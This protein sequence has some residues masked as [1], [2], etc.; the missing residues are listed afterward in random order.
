MIE[1]TTAAQS[2]RI[3]TIEKGDGGYPASHKEEERDGCRKH[4]FSSFFLYL[5]LR[6]VSALTGSA[7]LHWPHVQP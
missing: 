7:Q 3:T 4:G 5:L 1:Q 2:T 6:H